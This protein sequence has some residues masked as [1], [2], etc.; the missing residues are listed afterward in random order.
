MRNTRSSTT[1]FERAAASLSARTGRTLLKH[2]ALPGGTPWLTTPHWT[3]SRGFSRQ[4][5]DDIKAYASR[6]VAAAP[7][8]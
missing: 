8:V 6:L 2:H 5:K 4:D 1:P 3:A 7:F